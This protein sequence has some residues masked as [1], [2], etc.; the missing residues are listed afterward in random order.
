ML[1]IAKSYYTHFLNYPL[2]L[3]FE[4][5]ISIYILHKFAIQSGHE[6]TESVI[7]ILFMD[8]VDKMFLGLGK[9]ILLLLIRQRSR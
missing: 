9:G 5:D 4:N 1:Y 3:C 7:F 8:P 2:E 6:L